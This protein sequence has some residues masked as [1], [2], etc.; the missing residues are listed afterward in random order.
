MCDVHLLVRRPFSL[1]DEYL[2]VVLLLRTTE[3]VRLAVDDVDH[4]KLTS[5][6]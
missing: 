6:S 3:E 2:L 5:R 4:Q 1:S